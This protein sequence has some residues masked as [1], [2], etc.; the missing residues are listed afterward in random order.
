MVWYREWDTQTQTNWLRWSGVYR[1]NVALIV[2]AHM[3][4]RGNSQGMERAK[5]SETC[6]SAVFTEAEATS[7]GNFQ[8]VWSTILVLPPEYINALRTAKGLQQILY[9]MWVT[10][11][12]W[13]C[14]QAAAEA[15]WLLLYVITNLSETEGRT[16]TDIVGTRGKLQWE[17]D[18]GVR[19]STLAID[20]PSKL[21]K[22]G[23]EWRCWSVMF[24]LNLW[25]KRRS[26]RFDK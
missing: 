22:R 13:K 21:P 26:L 17:R 2:C 3:V 1:R 11:Q 20:L 5:S 15:T 23:G 6:N 12:R 14:Q 9:T 10:H 8:G 18:M 7:W 16:Q 25:F 24:S 19:A 4:C